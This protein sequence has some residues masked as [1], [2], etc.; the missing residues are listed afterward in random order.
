[1]VRSSATVRREADLNPAAPLHMA[2]NPESPEP[3]S[4]KRWSQRK[5]AAAQAAPTQALPTPAAAT[6]AAIAP[7]DAAPVPDTSPPLPPVDSLT[8]DSDYSAFMQ[9]KIAEETKRAALRKLFSD[10]SFNVMDGLDIY[11][12]D[13]TQSDPMPSGMLEK[14][15]A[16][17]AMLDPVEP[18]HD[19]NGGA[20]ENAGATSAATTIESAPAADADLLEEHV[21][22]SPAE[23]APSTPDTTAG[24][25]SPKSGST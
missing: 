24:D 22:D 25:T 9:P 21:T 23:P 13:Y 12:G 4:L 20:D 3:F 7:A 6:P 18:A 1:M 14:L 19:E 2:D 5:R 8:F 15:T 16:A 17:Y 10:P 11:V